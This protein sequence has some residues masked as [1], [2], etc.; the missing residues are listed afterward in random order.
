MKFPD[1]FVKQYKNFLIHKNATGEKVPNL[2]DQVRDF[3]SA[4]EYAN[5]VLNE[6]SISDLTPK[7]LFD[8]LIKIHELA[9]PNL[10]K[11]LPQAK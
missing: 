9:C 6:R 4:V 10:Y 8:F 5:S 3:S 11:T 2:D 1:N 7:K